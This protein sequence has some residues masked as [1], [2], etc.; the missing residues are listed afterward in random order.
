SR[1]LTR[2]HSVVSTE[3]RCDRLPGVVTH[4]VLVWSARPNG[5]TVSL[6]RSCP[7][8]TIGSP[9][10]WFL[11]AAFVIAALLIDF[12]ALNRQGAHRVS[13]REAGIWT[14]TW[15]VVSFIFVGLLWWHMGGTGSDAAARE[16]ANSK[17][18]EFI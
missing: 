8:I 14:L 12:F 7:M 18:L 11:F 5:S 6:K 4:T 9:L 10:L 16:L 13:M 1:G 2:S 3:V 15:V 17:A